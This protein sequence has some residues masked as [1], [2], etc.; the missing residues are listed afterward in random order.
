VK[1]ES[2]QQVKKPGE[3]TM[4]EALTVNDEKGVGEIDE[5]ARLQAQLRL[6]EAKNRELVAAK[7]DLQKEIRDLLAI[8]EVARSIT[9]TLLIEEVLGAILRGIRQTLSL[10]RV[11]LSLVHCEAQHEEV[12]LAVG[13]PIDAIRKARWPISAES[14]V[15]QELQ[16][17]M[18]PIIIDPG[19]KTELPSFIREVF[20]SEFVKAPMI[21]K[22]EI[23]GTIMVSRIG[24]PIS[25]R[26]LNLLRI[27]V[28]YAAIAVENGRLYYDVIRSQDELE[29]TQEQLVD[30][31]RLAAIGQLAV[32]INHEINNPLCT[33]NMSAQLLRIELAQR[34]PESLSRL[35][36]IEQAVQRIMNVTQKVSKMSKLRSTEYLPNQMMIDLK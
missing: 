14:N 30:A 29:K 7:E 19:R 21:A 9:S 33:I 36:G 12:K 4:A 28:E 15:W 1:T 27:L 16:S 11:I 26:D 20:E 17:E 23:I 3:K 25:E 24:R 34:S 35:D 8:G 22:G 6:T 2:R 31:E 32:S 10:D 5:V 18:A 13:V